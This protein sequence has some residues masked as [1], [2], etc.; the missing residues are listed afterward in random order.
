MPRT[1]S[2][3]SSPLPVLV[4]LFTLLAVAPV[5][6][7]DIY[8]YVD[9]TGAPH[10]TD[11]W[12]LIPDKYRSRVEAL[13]PETGKVFKPDATGAAPKHAVPPPDARQ[14][15]APAATPPEAPFYTAWLEQFS[16]LSIPLPSQ[17]Q[18]GTGLMSIVFVWGAFKIMRISDSPLVKLALKGVIMIIVIGSVYGLYISN[19]NKTI[20]EATHDTTPKSASGKTVLDTLQGTAEQA[21]KNVLEQV[22]APLAKIKDATVGGAIDARDSMNQSNIEKQN[23]LQK[24][25]TEP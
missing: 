14:D 8:K 12:Q 3:I 1:T 23:T 15:H 7:G 6:A 24:I 19:L 17:F 2:P 9:D 4:C 10:Y 18:L 11:Q 13:D 21:Q 20:S 16:A 22:A 5:L 25:E